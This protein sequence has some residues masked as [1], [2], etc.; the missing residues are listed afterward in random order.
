[1]AAAHAGPFPSCSVSRSGMPGL[2]KNAGHIAERGDDAGAGMVSAFQDLRRRFCPSPAR[3]GVHLRFLPANPI[4]RTSANQP[5]RQSQRRHAQRRQPSPAPRPK[6]DQRARTSGKKRKR[7]QSVA[8]VVVSVRPQT[9]NEDR[10]AARMQAPDIEDWRQR[11]QEQRPC[12]AFGEEYEGA[13]RGHADGGPRGRPEYGRP[14]I[15]NGVRPIMIARITRHSGIERPLI[16]ALGRP[17]AVV[18]IKG[19]LEKY[20]VVRQPPKRSQRG[21]RSEDKRGKPTAAASASQ[22]VQRRERNQEPSFVA[23]QRRRQVCDTRRRGPAKRLRFRGTAAST[24]AWQ[25]K[26]PAAPAP[27]S[28]STADRAGW[29]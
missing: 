19:V 20:V 22:D 7:G 2:A 4:F 17:R 11:Q 9:G 16:D 6:Q 28:A 21:D 23:R 3:G 1:M 12:A 24:R 18:E 5:W 14:I 10:R 15:A 25:A 27:S 29:D 13:G 8:C 26:R